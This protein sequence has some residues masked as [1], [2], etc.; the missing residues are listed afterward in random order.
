MKAS[1]YAYPYNQPCPYCA[2]PAL[3]KP[4]RNPPRKRGDLFG[5]PNKGKLWAAGRDPDV[6]AFDGA[7][8]F[9]YRDHARVFLPSAE[10]AARFQAF[11]VELVGVEFE[12][13]DGH[14][15]PPPPLQLTAAQSWTDSRAGDFINYGRVFAARVVAHKESDLALAVHW[16]PA[17]GDII[18]LTGTR[19][20][21]A[22]ANGMIDL[23]QTALEVFREETRGAPK[24]SRARLMWALRR[25]GPQAT[26]R[27]VAAELG[28]GEST[29]SEW[30]R[31]EG[32]KLQDLKQ[33][34]YRT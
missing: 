5:L 18:Q 28:A 22:E 9:T 32:V 17:H 8:L 25:Q 2:R 26:Q 7:W 16:W 3:L 27:A 1:E 29:I 12:M 30:L 34:L 15:L 14:P 33:L 19:P 24:L 11:T 4:K 20:P 6:S 13:P 23:T 10:F 31:R 21:G